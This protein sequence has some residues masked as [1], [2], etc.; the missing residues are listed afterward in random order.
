MVK[1]AADGR[2]QGVVT[3]KDIA[4]AIEKQIG[5][6]IDKRKITLSTTINALGSYDVKVQLHKEVEAIISV[7]IIEEKK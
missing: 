5:P 7:Y 3:S 6:K 4:E 1:M 2:I